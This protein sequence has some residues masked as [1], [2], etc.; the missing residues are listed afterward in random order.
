M[1]VP[2]NVFNTDFLK[3]SF[4]KFVQKKNIEIHA[5]S[6]FLQGLLLTDLKNIPKKFVRFKKFFSYFYNFCKD[7]EI[8][9]VNYCLNFIINFSHISKIVI[10]FKNSSFI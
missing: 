2:I 3:K 9:R 5:R 8:S 6:I 7:N 1:Q 4:I 10:G